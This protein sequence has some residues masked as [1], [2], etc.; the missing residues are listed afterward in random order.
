[1]E[2]TI[3]NV[4]GMTCEHCVKAIKDSV[5][6]LD[7]V[8]HVSVDITAM[9]VTVKYNTGTI[10]LGKIINEIEDQGYDVI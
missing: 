2:T 3:L 8:I 5:G 4:E 1:M 10:P 9:T 7:G 6:A